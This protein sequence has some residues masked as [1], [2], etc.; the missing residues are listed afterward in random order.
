MRFLRSGDD[1]FMLELAGR[2]YRLLR[3]VIRLFPRIPV[4]YHQLNPTGDPAETAA[5]QRLLEESLAAQKANARRQLEVWLDHANRFR[6]KAG[7]WQ[8][9]FSASE[10]DWFLQILND[11]RVGSWL[12]LG[13]PP[14]LQA[15][16]LTEENRDDIVALEVC[17]LAQTVILRGLNEEP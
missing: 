10:L 4:A 2:E 9:R 17:G 7:R 5:D 8:L 15:L 16:K 14:D 6:S 13:S 3:E 1:R 11:V 12:R